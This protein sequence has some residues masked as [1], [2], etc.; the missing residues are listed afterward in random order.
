MPATVFDPHCKPQC[1]LT[2]GWM[3]E[4]LVGG[5]V[6]RRLIGD[7]CTDE[8]GVRWWTQERLLG[9]QRALLCGAGQE[10]GKVRAEDSVLNPEDSAGL[11]R[12]YQAHSPCYTG[13]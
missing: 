3:D 13:Y 9:C 8:T 10:T 11:P 1:G 12:Q 6:I 4:G 2:D 7:G 5:S